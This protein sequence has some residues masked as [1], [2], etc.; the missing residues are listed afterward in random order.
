MAS[1]LKYL[2]GGLI[3]TPMATLSRETL[4]WGRGIGFAFWR[5]PG[6]TKKLS[7]AWRKEW[8]VESTGEAGV[9]AEGVRAPGVETEIGITERVRAWCPD[10][11]FM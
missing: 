7:S 1:L 9:E 2:C 8:V 6:V 5:N 10:T 4:G 3:H 11:P